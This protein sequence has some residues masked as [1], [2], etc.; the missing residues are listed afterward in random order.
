M[1]R[2]I[3]LSCLSP[4]KEPWEHKALG[5]RTD[6]TSRLNQ[7]K[8]SQNQATWIAKADQLKGYSLSL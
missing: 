3:P 1:G 8:R 6:P 5:L 7:G 4:N 2:L